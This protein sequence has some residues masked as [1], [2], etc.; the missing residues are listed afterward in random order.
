[1]WE[2][3]QV[4]L[5]GCRSVGL[6]AG[7]FAALLRQGTA[8]DGSNAV[9]CRSEDEN[10]DGA[11]CWSLL[12][13]A[14]V[15]QPAWNFLVARLRLHDAAGACY[16]I[17]IV[18]A[19]TAAAVVGGGSG[20]APQCHSI[21]TALTSNQGLLASP[22][23]VPYLTSTCMHLTWSI[24]CLRPQLPVSSLQQWPCL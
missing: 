23:C 13:I 12:Q 19:A 22:C 10:T 14:N 8:V 7:V 18:A 16:C 6:R 20:G 1:M 4:W 3:A 17:I 15:T 5:L 21:T 9:T 24:V 11:V 2:C